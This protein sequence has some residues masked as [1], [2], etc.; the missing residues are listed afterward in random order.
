LSGDS[1][2]TAAT[3]LAR[4]RRPSLALGCVLLVATLLRLGVLAVRSNQT[5]RFLTSDSHGYLTLGSDLSAF[6]S[7]S[8]PHFA[9][10]LLRT[11]VYPLY[12]TIT[13][14]ITASRIIGP[15]LIQVA[16][17][18]GVVYLTY[19]LGLSLFT[20]SVALCGAA[21]LAIDPISIV[22]S[23]LV[24]TETLFALFLVWSVLLLWRPEDNR[25]LRGLAAGLLLGLAT[26]T[27]PVSLYLSVVLAICY[28]LLERKDLKKAV[29][30]ALSFLIGFGVLAGGWVIRNDVVANDPTVS[31]IEGYNLLY[32]RAAG[33]LQ[34]SQG[35]SITQARLDLA[36]QLAT[37]LHANATPGEIDKTEQSLATTVIRQHLVGYGKEVVKGGGRLLAGPGNDEFVPATGGHAHDL[38][39]SYG[40]VYLVALYVLVVIGLWAAW[41]QRRLRNCF[42]PIVVVLYLL[43]VSSGSD[44]YSRFRSPLMPFFAVLAGAGLVGLNRRRLDRRATEPEELAA[45]E[46]V[47]SST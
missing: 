4:P 21:V 34:E 43:L 24:L 38:V 8:N 36:R 32:Y 11:P 25:W 46:S 6:T 10:G 29:L 17:G 3:P 18:V 5:S 42:I 20:P 14:N 26:L 2:S 9:L 16:L 22:Y 37:K 19:R 15:M 41:R 28:L 44:A 47:E 23:S 30:V 12:L 35:I 40:L 27:R 39:D 1:T 45:T 13:Q 31:T 7:K 33:A